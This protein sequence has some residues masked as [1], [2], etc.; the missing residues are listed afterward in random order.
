M[1]NPDP[2]ERDIEKKVCEYARSLG[3]LVYKFTSPGRSHVPD[4]LFVLPGGR[5]FFIEFKRLGKKPTDAQAVEIAKLQKQGVSV[6]V[7]DNVDFGK[8]LLKTVTKTEWLEK[9]ALADY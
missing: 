9:D 3:M 5:V 7:V 6:F 1:K 4:R 8:Q 2:L